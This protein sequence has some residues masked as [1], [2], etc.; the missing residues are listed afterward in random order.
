MVRNLLFY[1]ILFIFSIHGLKSQ[2]TIVNVTL[3]PEL[4]VCMDAETVNVTIENITANPI[5]NMDFEVMLPNGIKY[6]L[7]TV[8]GA[9]ELTTSPLV[10]RIPTIAVGTIVSYSFDVEAFC[11]MVSILNNAQSIDFNITYNGNDPESFS[12]QPMNTVIR[13]PELNLIGY[14]N[15]N[16]IDIEFGTPEQVAFRINN[17]GDGNIDQFDISF[18]VEETLFN[19][20]NF[21]ICGGPILP[22]TK[23]GSNYSL[24][25]TSADLIAAGDADGLFS[26]DE[27]LDFCFDADIITCDA[28]PQL[29]EIDYEMSWGCAS[30]PVCQNETFKSILR[31][32][33][34]L[35]PALTLTETQSDED[36]CWDD[37]VTTRTQVVTLSNSGG[38]AVNVHGFTLKL[39]DYDP[40]NIF[41]NIDSASI[42]LK[43]NGATVLNID[44]FPVL[45]YYFY[46]N[47]I[48]AQDEG[49]QEMEAR[50]DVIHELQPGDNLELTYALISC[51]SRENG[52]FYS[53]P[54]P[55]WNNDMNN[56]PFESTVE[57][58][59]SGI[60][61][62][63]SN[64]VVYNPSRVLNDYDWRFAVEQSDW[65]PASPSPGSFFRLQITGDFIANGLPTF[66]TDG[67]VE[68]VIRLK[69]GIT[70][71]SGFGHSFGNW[72]PSY[73]DHDTS[74][75]DEVITLRYNFP[76]P[77]FFG[78][79]ETLQIPNLYFPDCDDSP[80]GPKTPFTEF[81]VYL[82]PDATCSD[83]CK[84][85][86]TNGSRGRGIT[87]SP[88]CGNFPTIEMLDFEVN[89]INVGLAD[90]DN[91]G[92][93]DGTG[94]AMNADL[95]K[96][97]VG[98]DTF[99][100]EFKGLVD[101]VKAW[102][103]GFGPGGMDYL[104]IGAVRFNNTTG[105]R[106]SFNVPQE[107]LRIKIY[108]FDLDQYYELGPIDYT[109]QNLGLSSPANVANG[110]GYMIKASDLVVSGLDPTMPGTYQYDHNDTIWVELEMTK[111][112]KSYSKTGGFNHYTV[113][114]NMGGFYE[115]M[116]DGF[117]SCN[118][119]DDDYFEYF[120]HNTWYDEASP[121][122][123]P[124]AS[125]NYRV[126][127]YLGPDFGGSC[128]NFYTNEY[129]PL[130]NLERL[131]FNPG[132]GITLSNISYT[133][134]G[135]Q[136]FGGNYLC[137]TLGTNSSPSVTTVPYV[138][139]PPFATDP[140]NLDPIGYADFPGFKH[141][142][143]SLVI[144]LSSLPISEE[145]EN[146]VVSF[147]V[148]RTCEM[149]DTALVTNYINNSNPNTFNEVGFLGVGMEFNVEGQPSLIYE[150]DGNQLFYDESHFINQPAISKVDIVSDVIQEG[151]KE[152][153]C[154][155][156]ELY[157]YAGGTLQIYQGTGGD[158]TMSS[159]CRTN[160][161]GNCITNYSATNGFYDV[162]V[163]LDPSTPLTYKVCATDYTCPLDSINIKIG[164][165]QCGMAPI[166][167]GDLCSIAEEDAWL[168]VTE[169][170]ADI[171]GNLTLVNA[172]TAACEPF[173]YELELISTKKGALGDLA[174]EIDLPSSDFSI[175]DA[176]TQK[177]Y[178]GTSSFSTSSGNLTNPTGDTW[179]FQVGDMDNYV[180]DNGLPG[181][182]TTNTIDSN[183]IRVQFS[184][185]PS[186][187]AASD[188]F[189]PLRILAD[190]GCTDVTLITLYPEE[191]MVIDGADAESNYDITLDHVSLATC[192]AN[193]QIR[194]DIYNAGPA[195]SALDDTIYVDFPAS[196]TYLTSLIPDVITTSTGI[197]FPSTDN[198]T[199]LTTTSYTID[200]TF[201]FSE[202]TCDDE[203]L[204]KALNVLDQS[205]P[206]PSTVTCEVVQESGEELDVFA[207]S[208][209]NYDIVSFSGT[210][211]F[212]GGLST[213]RW[214][215]SFKLDNLGFEK[216]AGV[217]LYVDFYCDANMNG[218]YD[219][220]ETYLYT[221]TINDAIAANGS[222]T[223]T[224][225]EI[226][227]YSDCTP[228]SS[229]MVMDIRIDNQNTT[230]NCL[231]HETAQA[232]SSILPVELVEFYGEKEGSYNHLFWTTATEINTDR[233]EIERSENARDFIYFHTQKAT[234]NSTERVVYD[235]VDS[236]PFPTTYYRLKI[237]DLDGSFEY[238]DIVL[239]KRNNSPISIVNLYPNP[240]NSRITLDLVSEFEGD[241]QIQI[242]DVLGR[243]LIDQ[244]IP[245]STGNYSQTL[246]VSKLAQGIYY[247]RMES[248]GY[249]TMKKF[250]IGR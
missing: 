43:L 115:D 140:N 87:C 91:D 145:G 192:D 182:L 94:T 72:S 37:K 235:W 218:L 27:S 248:N 156:L 24:T 143:D 202:M 68:F 50:L 59:T 45:K 84:I 40:S 210:T 225:S 76:H 138:Y 10:F 224:D 85:T 103:Y 117:F 60:C 148:N 158:M 66:S 154:W 47:C 38:T 112:Y 142:V 136:N 64:D 237:I 165:A 226:L 213:Y 20:S 216:P 88:N 125:A 242:M 179:R 26:I 80:F 113:D 177:A 52:N 137:N 111:G 21:N 184:I 15:G 250:V 19:V 236:S 135:T 90:D 157:G 93:P 6:A 49:Y 97:I 245:L 212:N 12:S 58:I 128:T 188:L 187:E 162:P 150:N 161:L 222:Y 234:G 23:T 171:Q 205:C 169:V 4:E 191:S 132:P 118:D 53:R 230:D 186:C 215:Y 146:L 69:D 139:V 244:S 39:P 229:Q 48:N 155:D 219:L 207:F 122:I 109:S 144:D 134:Y 246:D 99:K 126:R 183:R 44:T 1:F 189:F 197:K 51:C 100:L 175:D 163:T 79:D 5:T 249:Y 149:P 241:V 124:C 130:F 31:I 101:T 193:G 203:V 170:K 63:S 57:F 32:R 104:F 2:N 82:Y 178:P 116:E 42:E 95:K 8:S 29:N 151:I 33:S 7:G 172:P 204:V 206:A 228:E 211:N 22:L 159:F 167:E 98:I 120:L 243:K 199:A 41:S 18:T 17:G 168:Y 164:V 166:T 217:P 195:N 153:I 11:P 25:V 106:S 180:R 9:T 173:E 221:V 89:R 75:P 81:D 83:E 233:F 119:M 105:F 36:A 62:E 196:M 71:P 28:L 102:E 131:Y 55:T 3:P 123:G 209:P 56:G 127:F 185:L 194:L 74:G 247:V 238:S 30:D 92:S 46:N 223:H 121:A 232:T 77:S 141:Q 147:T 78:W 110:R 174:F 35:P 34:P 208:I 152:E 73:F 108:D 201:D 61:G 129:R 54:S 176:Q 86:I 214:D 227:N 220:S 133:L 67:Y 190:G 239:L 200:Y 14:P 107:P 16:T 65:V 96:G 240:A 13:Y 181:V 198:F 160:T 114:G 231:C 70:W